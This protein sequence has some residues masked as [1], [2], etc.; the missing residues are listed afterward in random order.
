MR[1]VAAFYFAQS[2]AFDLKAGGTLA[3]NLLGQAELQQQRPDRILPLVHHR[4]A[5]S[6][7]AGNWRRANPR[8]GAFFGESG[9]VG[10]TLRGLAW[11]SVSWR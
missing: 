10:V 5:L 9:R 11:P 1:T 2:T 3:R 6:P 7:W 8:Q 4:R